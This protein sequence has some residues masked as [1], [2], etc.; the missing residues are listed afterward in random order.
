MSK[1]LAGADQLQQLDIDF[2]YDL[3]GINESDLGDLYNILIDGKLGRGVEP[4]RLEI[5]Q[6][7]ARGETVDYSISSVAFDAKTFYEKLGGRNFIKY[8]MYIFKLSP[9]LKNEA[10]DL[11]QEDVGELWKCVIGEYKKLGKQGFIKFWSGIKANFKNLDYKASYE[12]LLSQHLDSQKKIKS[13]KELIG[14]KDYDEL[15]ILAEIRKMLESNEGILISNRNNDQLNNRIVDY[16]I[17]SIYS[18]LS[19]KLELDE[20]G[21]IVIKDQGTTSLPIEFGQKAPVESNLSLKDHFIINIA[22]KLGLKAPD[23]LTSAAIVP[24]LKK[25]IAQYYIGKMRK[26]GDFTPSAAFTRDVFQLI[27]F[28]YDPAVWSKKSAHQ[29]VIESKPEIKQVFMDKIENSLANYSEVLEYIK[30]KADIIAQIITNNPKFFSKQGY[31]ESLRYSIISGKTVGGFSH[32]EIVQIIESI[33]TVDFINV[34]NSKADVNKG[35]IHKDSRLG[36]KPENYR[37]LS[38]L[39]QRNQARVSVYRTEITRQIVSSIDEIAQKIATESSDQ[40]FVRENTAETIKDIISRYLN[41][42]LLS[43]ASIRKNL[44]N[45]LTPNNVVVKPDKALF[46]V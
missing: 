10:N 32:R 43:S 39:L 37:I 3:P 6:G 25:K 11:R 15:S 1:E 4:R 41:T 19:E 31:G 38:E 20:E 24:V 27:E 30:G 33:F 9:T 18:N 5:F 28:Y 34:D 16:V 17:E 44:P 13:I 14:R 35:S 42:S 22:Q 23:N 29:T 46:D 26:S 8:L 36:L 12:K 45:A 40:K 7:Y 21:K 2:N